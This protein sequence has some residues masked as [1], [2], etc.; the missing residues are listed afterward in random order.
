MDDVAIDIGGG[1]Q[2][3][4]LRHAVRMAIS[5]GEVEKAIMYMTDIATS[6]RV[7]EADPNLASGYKRLIPLLNSREETLAFLSSGNSAYSALDMDSWQIGVFWASF[8][9]DYELAERILADG[10]RKDREKGVLA[11]GWLNYAILNPLRNSES[12]KQMVKDH[13]LDNFWRSNGYPESCRPL[14][15]D[16]FVCN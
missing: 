12:Y 5:D 4:T 7:I 10:I 14:G 16:D 6:R 9:G 8:Y 11:S 2:D 13:K 3:F 1:D 15:E